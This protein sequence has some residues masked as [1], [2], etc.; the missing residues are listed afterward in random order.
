MT[1]AEE[2]CFAAGWLTAMMTRFPCESGFLCL[3]YE[4]HLNYK[5]SLQ[6]MITN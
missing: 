6:K 2:E 5:Y 1:G 3:Q 4:L